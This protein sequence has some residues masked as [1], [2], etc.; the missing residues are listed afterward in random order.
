MDVIPQHEETNCPN[1]SN[2]DVYLNVTIHNNENAVINAS[3]QETRRQ[4]L[5]ADQ[6]NYKM[7]IIRMD[8]P[9]TSVPYFTYDNDM[10]VTLTYPAG[11]LISEQPL[12]LIPVYFDP[13]IAQQNTIWSTG[14]ML[15]MVNNALAAAYA[16]L[17]IQ[18]GGLPGTAPQFAPWFV[19]D[20]ESKRFV[21]YADLEH[22]DNNANRIEVWVNT[23]LY[24]RLIPSFDVETYG[25]NLAN[26]QDV[27]FRFAIDPGFTNVVEYANPPP[28]PSPPVYPTNY[29]FRLVQDYDTTGNWYDFY[30]I[31]VISRDINVRK[32]YVSSRRSDGSTNQ[33][34]IVTDFTYDFP[35][36]NADRITYVPSAEYR[37]MDL[38][39]NTPLDR[40]SFQIFYQTEDT[41]LVPV[42]LKP[43]ESV[44]LKILFRKK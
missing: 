43:G 26:G 16:D 9:S 36:N 39:N 29:V 13:S 4:P 17:V 14:Q 34:A 7:S 21:L 20:S 41:K 10:S 31:V 38:L 1:L 28:I 11:G 37:F 8:M 18:S 23:N 6:S 12:T 19:Y 15:E 5:F 22:A 27:R 3:F 40:L 25:E 44:N 2:E 33:L 32:E 42:R 35:T 24:D 30:K